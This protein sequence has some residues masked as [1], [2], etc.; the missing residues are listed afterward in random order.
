MT[1]VIDQRRFLA[2][3]FGKS[4]PYWKLDR[5]YQRGVESGTLGTPNNPYTGPEAV[6]WL[7]G[8]CQAQSAE[9]QNH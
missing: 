2:T 6:A 3:G 8:Y 9:H 1:H 5:S 4:L 7:R